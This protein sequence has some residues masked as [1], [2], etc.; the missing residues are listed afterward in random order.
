MITTYDIFYYLIYIICLFCSIK[1]REEHIPGLLFLRLLLYCGLITEGIVEIMQYYELK[2]S[3]NIPYY[4]YIPTEYF[5]LVFFYAKNTTRPLLKKIMLSSTG[6]Y[7]G[8]CS[9]IVARQQGMVEYPAWVYSSSCVLNTIWVT[10]LFLE[11]QYVESTGITRLPVFWIYTGLLVFYAS[12]FFF[13]GP[14]SYLLKANSGLAD[15]LRTRLNITMNYVL[16]LTLTYGFICS[17]RMKRS[18]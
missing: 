3:E 16:Y 2:R 13:N 7:L 14:Y 9:Y 12:V 1:A 6:I 18:S 11:M 8:I 15:T 17:L 5:L 4:F 10:L